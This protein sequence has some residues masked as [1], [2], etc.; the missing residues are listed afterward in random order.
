MKPMTNTREFDPVF[1]HASPRSGSTYFFSVLRHEKSFLCFNEAIIDGKEDIA[2]FRKNQDANPVASKQPQL[3]D[4]NHHFL[5]REDFYEF[6]E[7]WDAVAHLFPR[8][9]SFQN[10][11]PADGMPSAEVSAYLVALMEFAR[12]RGQRPVF[13]EIN[14]RGRAGAFRGAF[15]GFH[16]AQYR[17]PLSQFGSFIRAVTEAGFWGFLAF[18]VTELGTSAKHPLYRVMPEVWCA[19]D[20][21][22][23]VESR[24]QRWASDAQYVAAVGSL[25]TQNMEKVFRWHMFSWVLTNLAAISYSDLAIDIEKVHDDEDYRA[26]VI[27]N[28]ERGIGVAP[29]FRDLR[30]FVRY[31]EFE[32]F[33][34]AE[35]CGEV[36]ATI[37]E[38]AAD[39][40]L[41]MAVKA[42]G[43]QSP[44]TPTAA[45]VELL[46]GKIRD[47]LEAM[48]ASTHRRHFSAGEW[49]AIAARNQKIWFNPG[50]RRLAE[51]MYPLAAPLVRTSRRARL[52][53]RSRHHAAGAGADG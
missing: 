10:H 18:P 8:Y 12:S 4:L 29:D 35:V 28:L 13:C 36:S 25:Q 49:Q 21:P 44:T 16:I 7:A 22:W 38:A 41:G 48:K 42:L 34:M 52:W 37:R 17:D 20:I 2:R 11:L 43:P 53:Y 31:C 19:P 51:H 15:G 30:K 47:S 6:I 23:R 40:R 14:S 5:D 39:G 1:V 50:V 33:D 9:P 3:W 27:G 24:A 46:L 26:S 32:S 45:A